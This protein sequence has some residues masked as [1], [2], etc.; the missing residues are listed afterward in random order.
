MLTCS[1]L[2]VGG[3]GPIWAVITNLCGPSQVAQWVMNLP[4][5][6]ETPVQSLSQEDPLDA[7]M[8]THSNI[9]AWGIPKTEEPSGLQSIR[10][11]RVR[12]DSA[13]MTDWAHTHTLVHVLARAHYTGLSIFWRGSEPDVKTANRFTE[14]WGNGGNGKVWSF[15]KCAGI[16]SNWYQECREVFSCSLGMKAIR[17]RGTRTLKP[18]SPPRRTGEWTD[19]EKDS[20]KADRWPTELRGGSMW[21]FCQKDGLVTHRGN[22]GRQNVGCRPALGVTGPLSV[23]LH[24]HWSGHWA[25]NQSEGPGL[26]RTRVLTTDQAGSQHQEWNPMQAF[27]GLLSRMDIHPTTSW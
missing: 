15:C 16:N 9:L 14:K 27:P 26:W 6:Q 5:M 19:S 1:G 3:R 21:E 20:Q 17:P 8:V 24:A 7:G 23:T 11:Q 22:W 4:A 25:E 12:H 18:I 2:G 10:S 13:D